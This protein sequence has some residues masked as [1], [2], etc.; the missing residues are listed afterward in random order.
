MKT[1]FMDVLLI[2]L[3]VMTIALYLDQRHLYLLTGEYM[4]TMTNN[5][6]IYVLGECGI[7][8][9]I[10]SVKVIASNMAAKKVE[11]DDAKS[12][13]EKMAKEEAGK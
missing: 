7:M 10:K 11:I 13:L 3:I 12:K 2:A 1:K 4:Q 6:F 8:G 9:V 5:Y